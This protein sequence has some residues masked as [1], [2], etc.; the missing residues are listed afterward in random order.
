MR[1]LEAPQATNEASCNGLRSPIQ[2]LSVSIAS[3]RDSNKSRCDYR[4]YF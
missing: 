2:A 3:Q 1:L 4:A